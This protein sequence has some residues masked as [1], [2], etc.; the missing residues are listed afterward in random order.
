MIMN[1][2]DKLNE[3][4]MWWSRTLGH[5]QPLWPWQLLYHRTRGLLSRVHDEFE[6]SGRLEEW[7]KLLECW[8]CDPRVACSAVTPRILGLLKSLELDRSQIGR[9]L[10]GFVEDARLDG[11]EEIPEVKLFTTED[12]EAIF[13]LHMAVVNGELQIR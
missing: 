11:L 10:E 3:K 13:E 4:V 7:D 8:R 9:L 2:N 1:M 12:C 6:A 5:S